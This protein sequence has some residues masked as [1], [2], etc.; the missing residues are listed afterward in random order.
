M[1]HRRRNPRVRGDFG[2]RFIKPAGSV[3]RANDRTNAIKR[4]I[5]EAAGFGD[6]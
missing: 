5:N 2:P 3:D 4:R 1:E 6:H